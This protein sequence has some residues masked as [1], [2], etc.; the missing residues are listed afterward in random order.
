MD[1]KPEPFSSFTTPGFWDD[2]HISQS[3]LR[4]HLDPGNDL[5]SRRKSFID[6]STIGLPGVLGLAPGSRLLDLGCGPGLYATPF[7]RN[8]VAV[9]SVDASRRSL[10][11]ARS[12]AEQEGSPPSSGTATT[13]RPTSAAP[14]MRRS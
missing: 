8:G 13:S 14:T 10:R 9:L 4:S 12:L 7:A 2:P 1:Q 6:A 5:A 3:L 11:H